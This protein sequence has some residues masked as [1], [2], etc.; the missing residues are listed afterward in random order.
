MEVIVKINAKTR[1]A[2]H[3]VKLLRM[4][5]EFA[6]VITPASEGLNKDTAE[7]LREIK[8]KK[9]KRYTS[10]EKLVTDLKKS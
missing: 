5:P 8:A 10:V 3:Y 7:A 2:R 6:Q 1:Q 4:S 9:G